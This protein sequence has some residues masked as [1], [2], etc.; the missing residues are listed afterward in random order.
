MNCVTD[1]KQ[2]EGSTCRGT[3]GV[4]WMLLGTEES[5]I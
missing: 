3:K 4:E 5:V 1:G 2:S